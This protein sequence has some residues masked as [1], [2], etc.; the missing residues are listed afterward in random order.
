MLNFMYNESYQA[1]ENNKELE[2]ALMQSL[3]ENIKAEK[4]LPADAKMGSTGT[5]LFIHLEMNSIADLYD[6]YRLQKES[7]E[8]IRLI[9]I[10]SWSEIIDCYPAFLEA[11]FKKTNDTRL[12][13]LLVDVSLS[14]FDELDDLIF[15]D[16]INL[17][18]P[19]SFFSALLSRL[20]KRAEPGPTKVKKPDFVKVLEELFRPE[21]CEH[22]NDFNY[23]TVRSDDTV[24]FTHPG[25]NPMFVWVPQTQ[26]L[27]R[28]CY[29]CGG[30]S[31]AIHGQ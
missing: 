29:E 17:D 21:P 15:G 26:T 11:T 10:E 3:L 7:V 1:D 22:C 19:A 16:D 27:L 25:D 13:S 6:V 24:K 30:R 4:N 9:L 20:S 8:K 18:V 28:H 5:S 2:D 14:H 12:H 23:F 31:V